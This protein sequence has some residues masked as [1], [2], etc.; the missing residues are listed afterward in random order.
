M[1]CKAP[2]STGI[3]CQ[4]TCVND[5]HY[6]IH[7]SAFHHLYKKYK[8]DHG[9]LKN[10]MNKMNKIKDL[11]ALTI[12]DLLALQEQFQRIADARSHYR[13]V[14][15]VPEF[16]DFGHSEVIDYLL[17]QTLNIH[18]ILVEKFNHLNKEDVALNESDDESCDQEDRHKHCD[19]DKYIKLYARHQKIRADRKIMIA[20][21]QYFNMIPLD[22]KYTMEEIKVRIFCLKLLKRIMEKI[23]GY[24]ITK[25]IVIEFMVAMDKAGNIYA[26]FDEDIKPGPP[27][28]FCYRWYAKNF[29]E[30]AESQTWG[31]CCFDKLI[32]FITCFDSKPFI[33]GIVGH[34]TR[35]SYG[36]FT[37]DG[38]S[39]SI[40]FLEHAPTDLDRALADSG[41]LQGIAFSD[42]K[43]TEAFVLFVCHGEENDK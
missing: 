25:G 34:K 43:I 15:F 29:R 19:S 32:K 7:H 18:K 31:K 5:S 4:N 28:N 38:E 8:R 37:F 10:K 24:P 6:E 14:A 40:F 12:E 1:Q 21:E 30:Y 3:R 17:K 36:F 20:N 33:E 16:H 9:N 42:N 41:H 22:V 35:H 2:E 11:N 13:K 26:A 27:Q 23:L 39:Y